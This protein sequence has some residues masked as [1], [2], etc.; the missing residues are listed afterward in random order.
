MK[1]IEDMLL[2]AEVS[3][4]ILK[5]AQDMSQNIDQYTSNEVGAAA[6]AVA[7]QI[8]DRVQEGDETQ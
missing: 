2:Q 3:K 5:Y 6:D 7:I 8:I 1:A 4:L